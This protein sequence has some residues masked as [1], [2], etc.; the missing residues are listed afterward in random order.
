MKTDLYLLMS[1]LKSLFLFLIVTLVILS[2]FRI[3]DIRRKILKI[4][5]FR[6]IEF[7]YNNEFESIYSQLINSDLTEV[8]KENNKNILNYAIIL[9]LLIGICIMAFISM[10]IAFRHVINCAFLGFIVIVFCVKKKTIKYKELV[11]KKFIYFINPQIEYEVKNISHQRS[12]I[13]EKTM[14]RDYP[15]YRGYISNTMKYELDND[16]IVYLEDLELKTLFYDSASNSSEVFSG[17][18]AE[19]SRKET[20]D[21]DIIIKR[22]KMFELADKI[23][24]AYPEFERYFVLYS[25]NDETSVVTESIKEKLIYLYKEYKIMFEISIKHNNIYIRFFT[26]KI[27]EPNM[28]GELINKKQLYKEYIIFTNILKIINEINQMF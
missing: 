28:F 23:K 3:D 21:A 9:M 8:K 1:L 11:V 5:M 13:Y 24:E 18:I 20:L 4:K 22:N 25:A 6:N 27:F 7:E 14:F 12:K 15:L 16:T 17:I 10:P 2:L 26:G 19:I